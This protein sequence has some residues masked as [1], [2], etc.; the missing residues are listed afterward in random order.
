MIQ[1]I[2]RGLCIVDPA[3]FP[4]IIKK[5]CIALDFS[6][7]TL[8]HGSLEQEVQRDDQFIEGKASYKG[9]PG[10]GAVRQRWRGLRRH[11]VPSPFQ[12]LH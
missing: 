8:I 2:G 12:I 6:A 3:E 1:M 9:H 10:C 11:K 4:G 5:D 7:L